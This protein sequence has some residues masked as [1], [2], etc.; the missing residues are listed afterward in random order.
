MKKVFFCISIIMII[1]GAASFTYAKTKI[2]VP[3]TVRLKLDD[4]SINTIT[5]DEYLYGVVSSEM[6]TSYVTNGKTKQVGIEALKAQAVAART[7][8]LYNM[9]HSKYD[10]YDITASSSGQVYKTSNVKDIVKKAVDSTSGQV[11][12]YNGELVCTYFFTISGGHTES[13]ENIWTAA[14]PYARGVEDPYEP[15]IDGKSEWEARIPASKYGDMEVLEYSD[16]GRAIKM[17]IGDTVYS[18]NEIRSKL[19]YALIKSNWFKLKYDSKTDE[20]VFK[21][22]GYGHGVGMSQYGAMGMAEEGFDYEEILK[23][24]YTGIQITLG[25]TSTTKST[26]NIINEEEEDTTKETKND[27]SKSSIKVIEIVEEDEEIKKTDIDYRSSKPIV[28]TPTSNVQGPLLKKIIE[29]IK[30][31]R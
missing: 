22:K 31:W 12:T 8:A 19:G 7:Y 15:Y 30:S 11:I 21:G 20:Y 9:M 17:Q 10:G 2:E 16:N 13:S 14:L 3:E 26:K 5:F 4:G 6:G 27:S 1:L 25:N 29:V 28:I 24:Y 18:K 23:W